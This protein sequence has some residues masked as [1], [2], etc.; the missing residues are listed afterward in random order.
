[1]FCEKQSFSSRSHFFHLKCV[2]DYFPKKNCFGSRLNYKLDKILA[3][4]ELQINRKIIR[5]VI[6]CYLLSGNYPGYRE[7]FH[8][9]RKLADHPENIQLIRKISSLSRNFPGYPKTFQTIRKIS[10]LSGN[11]PGYPKTFLIIQKISSLS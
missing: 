9:I 2:L 7:T 10:R 4:T 1:M 8:A 3:I 5:K 11:F 6:I